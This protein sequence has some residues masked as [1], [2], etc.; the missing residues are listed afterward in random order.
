MIFL[1]PAFGNAQL[2]SNY[3]SKRIALS[4]DTVAIDTLSI[5]P[6]SLIAMNINGSKI[7]S[8]E[9]TILFP[10][11][12]FI[13]P[14]EYRML[15]SVVFLSYKVFPYNFAE[16]YQHKDVHMLVP[17]E[18][19]NYNPYVFTY[20]NQPLDIFTFGGLNKNGSISR[21]ISFGN[22]QDV[23]VNS[24]FNLQ[25]SGKLSEDIDILAAIT[26]NN[27][28]IQPEGNTQQLQDFD[29]IFIQLS[30]KNTK[31]IAGDYELAKPDS[32][33]MKFYKKA[34][35]GIFSSTID[36]GN[37]KKKSNDKITTSVAAAISKGKYAKNTFAGGEGNQ[38]PYKLTGAENETY[39]I[40]LSGTE[41]V[42]INGELM[43]RGQ[44]N[45][46]VI[47]YNTAELTFTTKRLITKDSR[48][49]IEFEYSDKNYSR[50]L[51]FTGN[52]YTTKNAKVRLNYFSEQDIKNQPLQQQL[53]D[54][55]KVLLSQIGDSLNLAVVP[56]VDSVAFSNDQVLYKKVD[57]L[58]YSPVY[59]YC[60]NSDSAHYRIGFTNVG[61]NK[62][63]Y[64][65]VQSSANGRVFQWVAPV[66][67][68]PQGDYS[69]V[70]LLVTP[71]KK[72]MVTL[73]ADYYI[74]KNTTTSVETAISNNDQN[75]FSSY[76]T[77]DDVG[78]GVKA[79]LKNVL[80]LAKDTTGWKLTSE[81]SHEYTGKTFS[82]VERYRDVE[83]ERNWNTTGLTLNTDQNISSVKLN[84]A[85][86]KD[87]LTYQFRSFLAGSFYTGLLHSA[88][89]SFEKKGFTLTFTGSFLNS[90]NDII[91][92]KYLRHNL[93]LSKKF[94][95]FTIGVKEDAENNKF[96]N[97][98]LPSDVLQTNSFAYNEYEGYVTNSDTSKNKFKVFY[99][100]RYDYLAP[101]NFMLLSTTA[102]SAGAS[103][104]MLKNSNNRL[105]IYSTYRRLSVNSPLVSMKNDESLLGRIDY[106]LK[107]LK[108]AMTW[109]TYY[110]VGSGMEVKKEFSY[111]EVAPGQG[112][113]SWTDYNG[114][115][116]AQLNEFEVAVFQDQANY[117]RVYIPTNEYVKTFTNQFS[118]VFS[119]NPSYAWTSPKGFKKFLAR[120][121]D[122]AT[123]SIDH[124]NTDNNEFRAY[125]PFTASVNDTA[126]V[127]EN[128]SFRNTFY[129]NRTSSKFGFDLTYK[130]AEN[131]I[132]LVNGVDTRTTM[133]KGINTKW[134]IA[135]KYSFNIKFN[136][137]EKTSA[138]EYFTSRDYDIRYNETMPSFTYQPGV[139]FRLILN[140]TYT[141][142]KNVLGT[143]NEMSF[144]N[145]AGVET[146][147]NVLSKG[148]LLMKINYIDI[149]YNSPENTSVA[150]EILEGLKNGKN[151]TWSIS[152][153][154]NIATNLQ[155]SLTYDGRKS[156]S[157]NT[158]HVG[159]VQLRAYF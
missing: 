54:S 22:S 65:Q 32:Y 74:S 129:F 53:S 95:S 144:M 47:D 82:P 17:D 46:Y 59:V 48:I 34:M 134:N 148:S 130:Q 3:R 58:G 13:M 121:S 91:N 33:F 116:I 157:T 69:P 29:K 93:G 142:K 56:N 98:N 136:E 25:L 10:E 79:Y 86:K 90:D 43:E 62:G 21:G 8:A 156:E 24:S 155:M 140:Y 1:F 16:T 41:K 87:F 126:L 152:Y 83:F 92:T 73:A 107:T 19:G 104:S 99:K 125:N 100:L 94:R 75:L 12:K 23:V 6:G 76:D 51:F 63:N 42:Y 11:S 138:S 45:D 18:K 77:G 84:L 26:D 111:V 112:V 115:G 124:K 145:K 96:Y 110:E 7:D 52:E 71:K 39:I 81:L 149:K 49:S 158:V 123:Y 131:K 55:E 4:S 44:E 20:E 139:S 113:Y 122:Q 120:F 128:S 85:K 97:F 2:L 36:V 64:I 127:S 150:Y 147:Y 9:Y 88:S 37:P 89:T 66:G 106:Y 67:G 135:R 108:G 38:G 28:P 133:E 141:E 57:S 153:Q 27:I 61:T 151:V 119:L 78:Y 35:G 137:G 101:Q 31:L 118:Q 60:T 14:K 105:T 70:V 109:S 146:K 117:I 50:S 5:I 114:D 132:L 40:V 103:Y 154:R 30:H 102:K 72:Q 68:V 143:S 159:S 15:Y 80:P